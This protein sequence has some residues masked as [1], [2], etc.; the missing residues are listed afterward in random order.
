MWIS[1]KRFVQQIQWMRSIGEIVDFARIL[2]TDLPNDR[3]W[4]ALTFDDGWKD[5][6]EQAFP[7]LKNHQVPAVIFL[8]TNAVNN[9][10]LFWPEDISTKIRHFLNN[11]T[12]IQVQKAL[13]DYWPGTGFDKRAYK[14]NVMEMVEGWIDKLKFVSEVER[15]QRINDC[16]KRLELSN[17]PLQGYI[18]SWDESREMLKYGVKF[19][20]HTHNHTILKGLPENLIESELRRSKK[21]ITEKLQVEVD[22]FCYPN[23][24]YNEKEGVLLARC[25]Y[26]YGF[27]L[28]NRTLR[29]CTDSYYIPRFLVSERLT[30]T[31]AYFNLRLLEVPLFCPRRYNPK[32]KWS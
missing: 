30:A 7:I 11:H 21:T 18:M 22:S 16:Y 26:R 15:Q 19:G 25:G 8:A 9:G 2:N 17:T 6:Y 27:C 1:P 20:S 31:P 24:S 3:P 13:I 28:N 14:V 23:A 5:N 12:E 10:T 32:S 29:H 4:F